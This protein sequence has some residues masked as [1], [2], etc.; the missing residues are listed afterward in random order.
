[1][2]A[3]FQRS[4]F[5]NSAFQTGAAAVPQGN[6]VL[7]PTAPTVVRTANFYIMIPQSNVVI[8]GTA[9]AFIIKD[10]FHPWQD[11][12]KVQGSID[13]KPGLKGN[14]DKSKYIGAS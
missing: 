11:V 4:A 13:I 5:Q 14:I 10:R 12:I 2:A 1:M 7:S 9:P 8:S 6:V 3:C